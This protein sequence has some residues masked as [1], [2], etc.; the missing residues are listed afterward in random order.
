[1]I[2]VKISEKGVREL[3]ERYLA[4][5]SLTDAVVVMTTPT[6]MGRSVV[7]GENLFDFLCLGSRTGYL[8]DSLAGSYHKRSLDE[9]I[10]PNWYPGKPASEWIAGKT[11]GYPG[12]MLPFLIDRLDLHPWTDPAHFD[13]LQERYA[14]LL[15][16]PPDVRV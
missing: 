12:N 7:V 10:D 8:L 6:D 3:V 1:M 2:G 11:D 5:H 15:R 16:L 9:L 14:S 4:E 13:E